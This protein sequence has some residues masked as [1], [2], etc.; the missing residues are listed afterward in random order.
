[1]GHQ[2][3]DWLGYWLTPRGLKPWREKLKLSCMWIVLTM[4]PNF[5]CSLDASTTNTICGGV[6]TMSSNPW[7]IIPVWKSMLQYLGH[8]KCE[9]H[10]TKCMLSWQLMLLLLILITTNGSIFTRM[11]RFS[12]RC[13]HHTGWLTSHLHLLQTVWVISNLHSNGEGD[14][15]YCSYPWRI[16]RHAPWCRHS[17]FYWQ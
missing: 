5:A 9:P 6:M 12:I 10:L 15:I 11:H 16:S 14:A 8:L 13:L 17:C 4:P 7:P 2:K 3:T 1:M